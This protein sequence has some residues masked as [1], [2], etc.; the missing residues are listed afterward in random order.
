MQPIPV[1]TTLRLPATILSASLNEDHRARLTARS[2]I[3]PGQRLAGLV[4]TD[5]VDV[6]VVEPLRQFRGRE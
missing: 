4:A 3:G 2:P 6:H 5:V 1:T